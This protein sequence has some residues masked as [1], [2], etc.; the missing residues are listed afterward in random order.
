M[1]NLANLCLCLSCLSL[2]PAVSY[3]QAV[4]LDFGPTTV[5]TAGT[6]SPYHTVNPL[7]TDSAWNTIGTS[8]QLNGLIW[9][10]GTSDSALSLDIG[11]TTNSTATVIGLSNVPSG[12]NALG[13][14]INTDVYAGDA[15]G[16]DAIYTGSSGTRYVGFQLGGLPA[17]TYDVYVNAR[18]TN[19]NTANLQH[20]SVGVSSV[21]GDFDAATL[22]GTNV[23]DYEAGSTAATEAWVE[24][25]N[26]LVFTV[27]VATGDYLNLAVVGDPAGTQTRGFLNSVQIVPTEAPNE[28]T[29]FFISSLNYQS[30]S[31]SL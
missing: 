18:N 30:G 17:G 16:T 7:F 21:S 11:A 20:V 29:I 9:S 31:L 15:A 28:G 24:S 2:I 10:D 23:L 3:S 1:R 4:L 8:D 22:E 6:N 26:Y 14:Q 27:T 5:S 25:E 19:T 12:S 13:S